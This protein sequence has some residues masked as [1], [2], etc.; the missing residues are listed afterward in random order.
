MAPENQLRSRLR[1]EFVR[2]VYDHWTV[3]KGRTGSLPRLGEIDWPKFAA[4]GSLTIARVRGD[5]KVQ[6]IEAGRAL[7]ELLGEKKAYMAQRLDK[8]PDESLEPYRRCA[9]E[10]APCHEFLK[11]DFGGGEPTT[12]ERLLLPFRAGQDMRTIYVV[13]VVVIE[14]VGP[15]DASTTTLPSSRVP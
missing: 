15:E 11:V 4:S 7:V 2:A 6:F 5:G 12:F 9:R 13:G 14:G 8:A 3:L 1:S 10:R